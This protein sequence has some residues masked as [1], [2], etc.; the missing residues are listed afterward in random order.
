[1]I[2]DQKAAEHLAAN[3]QRLLDQRDWTQRDLA[4]STGESEN[5]ISRIVRGLNVA[6][7]GILARIAEAFDVSSD[8]LLLPPPQKSKEIRPK[9][10]SRG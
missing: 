8:R 6:K 1:M 10:A 5:N 4:R 3:V 2:S 9:V 7:I